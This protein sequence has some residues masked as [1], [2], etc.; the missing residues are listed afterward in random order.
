M[1]ITTHNNIAIVVNRMTFFLK[2]S[3]KGVKSPHIGPLETRRNYFDQVTSFQHRIINALGRDLLRSLLAQHQ[4][5]CMIKGRM[6][7][8]I[9]FGFKSAQLFKINASF[10]TEYPR[11][12]EKIATF[13]EV[14]RGLCIRLLS[15]RKHTMVLVF[16]ITVTG[17][18]T[19]GANTKRSNIALFCENHALFDSL[20]VTVHIFNQMVRRSDD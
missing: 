8:V 19:C 4:I 15:E 9:K 20:C 13:Q 3:K 18:R 6:G 7:S 14:S 11:V 2:I 1:L 10:E 12:P 17:F 5:I 16:D